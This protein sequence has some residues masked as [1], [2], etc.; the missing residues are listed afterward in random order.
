M[1]VQEQGDM[2]ITE[3]TKLKVDSKKVGRRLSAKC[4]TFKDKELNK[5]LAFLDE[6]PRD[7]DSMRGLTF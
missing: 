3:K 6:L 4:T 7:F 2:E 1:L 5:E